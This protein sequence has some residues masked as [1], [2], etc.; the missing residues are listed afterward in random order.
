MLF[1]FSSKL[2]H[3]KQWQILKSHQSRKLKWPSAR[4]L[5]SQ[6]STETS[7]EFRKNANRLSHGVGLQLLL[8]QVLKA[9]TPYSSPAGTTTRSVSTMKSN[10]AVCRV[11]KARTVL[12]GTN[13]PVL[14]QM[15]GQDVYS[16]SHTG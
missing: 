8:S 5:S 15:R 2:A 10:P 14:V 1:V 7:T 16:Q 13:A 9:R 12:S 6:K 4:C 11:T 3:T